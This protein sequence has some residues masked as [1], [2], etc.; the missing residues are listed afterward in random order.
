MKNIA[1]FLDGTWNEMISGKSEKEFT[2]VAKLYQGA[3]NDENQVT[4]YF[5]GIGRRQA[6][7]AGEEGIIQYQPHK[8]MGG[9]FGLGMSDHIKDAYQ[10]LSKKYQYGDRVYLFGFSRGAFAA[11]SLAGFADAVGLLLADQVNLNL[12]EQAY[13]FYENAEDIRL[14]A[15]RRFLSDMTGRE[16]PRSSEEALPIY[17]IGVW[18]TVG[19]L[20]FS[21]F[22]L[23]FDAPFTQF[24]R[25]EL[26]A[27]VTHA[28]HALALHENRSL[29]S[30]VLWKGRSPNNKNQSLE[31]RWF[32]GAHSDV[33]GG[34][35]EDEWSDVALNWMA[36]EASDLDLALSDKWKFRL[37]RTA[38]KP[39]H[40]A[41]KGAFRFTPLG[42]REGVAVY[43]DPAA[44][45]HKTFTVD[46]SV[47]ARLAN[48]PIDYDFWYLV[49]RGM[50]GMDEAALQL[51]IAIQYHGG[52][53]NP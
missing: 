45:V 36:T 24:H 40:S 15:L 4:R 8:F 7:P 44:E 26:P 46:P 53:N 6:T 9:F 32:N 28:R 5:S 18:D 27:N 39:I 10:F 20:G 30:P 13:A 37:D 14:T 47:T 2:N 16:G 11:R 12:I 19:A 29:F 42:S 48:G 35:E 3:V 41:W 52:A 17:M 38:G 33:G 31:Q 1:L 43:P 51:Q 49:K 23:R 25:T 34:Y 50:V 22:P 21:K